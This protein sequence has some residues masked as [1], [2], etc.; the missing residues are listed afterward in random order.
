MVTPTYRKA[1]DS[2]IPSYI[3]ALRP[4]G[5]IGPKGALGD[6]TPLGRWTG[7]AGEPAQ[8]IFRVQWP[9]FGVLEVEVLFRAINDQ[10]LEEFVRGDEVTAWWIPEADTLPKDLIPLCLNRVG[11]WPMPDD[12]PANP[13]YPAY[14]GVF[15]DA[16]VPDLDS[17]FYEQ[18]WL[19]A[20][21]PD[22]W[23]LFRQPPGLLADGSQN[24]DAEN[25]ENL[26]K[27]NPDFYPLQ[28]ADMEKWASRRFLMCKPGYSRFGEP[29]H[30]DFDD[31]LHVAGQTIEADPYRE[32]L[33]GVDGGGNT[34]MPGAT[35]G[36]R[37]YEGHWAVLSEFSPEAQTSVDELGAE[38]LRTLNVRVKRAKGAVITIDPAAGIPSPQSPYTYAQ[39]LQAKTGIEVRMAPTN[40]PQ[41]RR[42]ALKAPLT[43]M[44]G[45]RPCFRVD[46]SCTGLIKALSGGFSYRKKDKAKGALRPIKNQSS[47]VAEACEYMAMTG[48]GVEGFFGGAIGQGDAGGDDLHPQP[49]M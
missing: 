25:L 43:R 13:P 3:N 46:P 37:T 5:W 41:R 8:H 33:I 1:W 7:G 6:K 16:N 4:L 9:S 31:E 23:H 28:A 48:D 24:P 35:Y 19:S 34:M 39:Q 14:A 44:V 11:R 17:W 29:V 36:Q 22:H 49:V 10:K 12:R 27:I 38:I 18:M 21:R 26:R 15:G 40:D 45:G 20:N 32:V 42:A 30:E 47:H 2:V